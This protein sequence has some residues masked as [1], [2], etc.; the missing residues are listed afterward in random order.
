MCGPVGQRWWWC[1]RCL[2]DSIKPYRIK[3]VVSYSVLLK[4][5]SIYLNL[6]ITQMATK[7]GKIASL[8]L[9]FD[10]KVNWK[11]R[12]Y[13]PGPPCYPLRDLVFPGICK[14]SYPVGLSLDREEWS[15]ELRKLVSCAGKLHYLSNKCKW[16]CQWG[17]SNRGV[18]SNSLGQ[19]EEAQFPSPP[20]LPPSTT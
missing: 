19:C 1:H 16:F 15:V 17:C 7:E 10:P 13:H 18:C 12:K 5:S 20:L 9:D 2:A 11:V 3:L 14:D 8:Q 6:K 4:P